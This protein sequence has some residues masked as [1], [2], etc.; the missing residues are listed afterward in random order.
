[1]RSWSVGPAGA[2]NRKSAKYDMGVVSGLISTTG[3]P[4]R[5]AAMMGSTT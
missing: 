1:M 2:A 4:R 5:A 3:M